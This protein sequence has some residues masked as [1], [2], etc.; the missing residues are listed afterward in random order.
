MSPSADAVLPIPHSAAPNDVT[1]ILTAG[2]LD[3]LRRNYDAAAIEMASK[4][5]IM[6]CYAGAV[7]FIDVL[8]KQFYAAPSQ[9]HSEPGA[10]AQ[11]FDPAARERILI[12]VLTIRRGGQGR[13]LAV[14]LYWGLMAGLSVQEIADQ[15]L[16]IGMYVG[17]PN[18]TAS[19]ATLQALLKRLKE[20]VAAG[21]DA[22]KSPTILERMG[23][24]FP[25]A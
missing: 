1:Q 6:G 20:S 4:V 7:G 16:L 18:F 10:R 2:E 13:F 9:R 24:W 14:H 17:L 21:G 22:L 25:T 23:T 3:Q 12:S 5:S 8:D 19:I 11:S 15:L